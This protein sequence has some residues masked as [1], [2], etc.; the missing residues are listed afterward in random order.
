M[1]WQPSSAG[2]ARFENTQGSVIAPGQ[3]AQLPVPPAVR[4]FY[5]WILTHFSV[6]PLGMERDSTRNHHEGEKRDI[7]EEGRACDFGVRP[8]G[9]PAGTTLA[10]WLVVHAEQLGVQLVIWDRGMWSSRSGFSEYKS[11]PYPSPHDDHVHAE[12]S[13][14]SSRWSAERMRAAL[15]A[16]WRAPA[17]SVPGGGGGWAGAALVAIGVGC[18]VAAMRG[19]DD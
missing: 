13:V 12:L 6:A 8:L 18:V 2:S 3:P 5:T 7:H 19:D 14:A 16:A 4:A 9:G 10:D 11:P 17:P 15:E 1:T